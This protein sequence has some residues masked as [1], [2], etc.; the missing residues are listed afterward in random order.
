MAVSTNLNFDTGRKDEEIS[1]VPKSSETRSK[2]PQVLDIVQAQPLHKVMLE[3]MDS[4]ALTLDA[5]SV[6]RMSTPCAQ[7]LLAT[8]L[9]A[10]KAGISFKICNAS[11][12]FQSALA[13]LGLQ[14][15][16]SNWIG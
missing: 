10:D 15:K 1:S 4:H 9:A 2:L 14:S 6:E 11:A 5:G 13:D 8:G 3:L 16:F 12:V 7:V